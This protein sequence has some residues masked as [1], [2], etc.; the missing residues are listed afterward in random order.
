[1]KI[2]SLINAMAKQSWLISVDYFVANALFVSQLLEGKIEVENNTDKNP[3][4]A[5]TNSVRRALYPWHLDNIQP[6]TVIEVPIVDAMLK[7]PGPCNHG[8][9]EVED[10][11]LLASQ[12]ENITGCILKIDSGG[13]EAAAVAPVLNGINVFRNSGKKIIAFC[14]VACSAAYWVAAA[15]DYIIADNTISAGF[16]SIGVLINYI[17]AVPYLEKQG[18]KVHTIYAPESSEKN[19]AF[20]LML[21]GK[22]EEITKDVLTPLANKF[23]ADIKSYRKFNVDDNH[24]VFKGADFN[25]ADSL[26]IGLIDKIGTYDDCI[27][28]FDSPTPGNL[29]S[30]SRISLSKTQ[31][32]KI[33]IT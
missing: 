19:K 25:A 18:Y 23:I 28:F 8:M 30:K 11:L 6:N 21:E 5:I 27:A 12:N 2:N 10:I 29:K 9:T 17:D 26:N 14:D 24:N 1:M 32:P 22:Y 20:R 13:G 16:G 7:H 4:Y 15:T 33:K 31:I 3:V